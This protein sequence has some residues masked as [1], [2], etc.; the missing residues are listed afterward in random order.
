M[1]R[2]LV[3]VVLLALLAGVMLSCVQY[4]FGLSSYMEYLP[5]VYRTLDS[6]YLRNDFYTN[7]IANSAGRWVFINLIALGGASRRSPPRSSCS[8]SWPTSWSPW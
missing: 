4:A 5:Q 8:P 6:N 3:S 1:P 7:A 2:G